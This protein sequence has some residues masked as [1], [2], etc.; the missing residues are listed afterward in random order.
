MWRKARKSA[1]TSACVEVRQDLNALR[2]SKNPGGPVLAAPGLRELVRAVR[3][4]Q[5]HA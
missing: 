1:D 5:V 3:V 2:D 4:G